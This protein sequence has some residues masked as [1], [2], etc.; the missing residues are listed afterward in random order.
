MFSTV[1][2][3]VANGRVVIETAGNGA[4]NLD[5]TAGTS[6]YHAMVPRQVALAGRIDRVR[7]DTN[8]ARTCLR[9]GPGRGP[10]SPRSS[11]ISAR[12]SIAAPYTSGFRLL[13][14]CE[15]IDWGARSL[16]SG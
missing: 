1:Q 10:W 16:A 13:R 7:A 2:T 15:E 11:E 5:G 4:Q 14:G 6:L 8:T 9:L 12:R 3:A